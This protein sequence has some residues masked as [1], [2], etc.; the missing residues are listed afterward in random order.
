MVNAPLQARVCESLSDVVLSKRILLCLLDKA[1]RSHITQNTGF[2]LFQSVY[3][4]SKNII[5]DISP[6]IGAY[7]E[8][9]GLH[10]SFLPG[11]LPT[12][13]LDFLRGYQ[14]A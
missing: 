10:P 14:R 6:A 5:L 3:R 12:A 9:L 7:L 8:V 1:S 11:C 4:Q 2:A 13:G